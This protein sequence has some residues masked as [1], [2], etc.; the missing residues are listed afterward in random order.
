MD[1]KRK[2]A[3]LL[4]VGAAAAASVAYAEETNVQAQAA[5]PFKWGGDIRLREVYF[6][7]IPTS[8]GGEARGGVN[9]FQR[10]RTRLWGEYHPNEEFYVRARLFNEFRTVQ[11]PNNPNTW[12]AFDETSFDNLFIDWKHDLWDIRIGR[13]DLIYGTGKLILDGTPLDGSRTIY[14]DAAK[15]VYKGID[16]TT[17]DF[18]AM[19]TASKDKL[20]LHSQ[21]RSVNGLTDPTYD[22]AEAGGGVYIKNK[23]HAELPWE[24][25]YIAKTKQDG[26]TDQL[27]TVGTRLMPKISKAID[28]NLEVAYQ[29]GADASAYM[30]DALGSWHIEALE[31]Q[32]GT[33]GLGWY[34]LSGDDPNST[35]DEGWNPIF[36]RWPQYSELYVYSFG[37][38]DGGIG[39]WSNVSMPHVDF[40][41]APCK[42]YKTELLLGYMFAPE[43]DGAGGGHNRGWLFTWWNHFTIAEKLFCQTDKLGGHFLLELMDPN[44]YYTGDQRQHTAVF[45]RA[46]LSYSF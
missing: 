11:E 12:S 35:Q 40:S 33:A 3:F 23:T 7:N 27:N 8:T 18:L 6:D 15:A 4:L 34:H 24:A 13:Q 30:I 14:F 32:K 26:M 20:A 2:T 21:D 28:G 1:I 36:A 9:H 25:Y 42:G 22:D 37:P 38:P 19:Y 31:E 44:D 46:E 17:V 43:D 39:R 10:Y 16:D 41:I 29:S 5:S 45:A